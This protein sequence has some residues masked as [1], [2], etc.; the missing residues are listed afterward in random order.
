[1]GEMPLGWF[2]AWLIVEKKGEVY[3]KVQFKGVQVPRFPIFQTAPSD[4]PISGKNSPYLIN[5]RIW[6]PVQ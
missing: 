6:K 3:P 4:T 2:G 1:M 5:H